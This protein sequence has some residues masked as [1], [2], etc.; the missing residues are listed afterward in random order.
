MLIFTTEPFTDRETGT[1][2]ISLMLVISIPKGTRAEISTGLHGRKM[3]TIRL[4]EVE[5]VVDQY[6]RLD[7]YLVSVIRLF[8]LSTFPFQAVLCVGTKTHWTLEKLPK[9]INYLPPLVIEEMDC[10]QP[11]SR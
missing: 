11:G 10:A 6:H 8:W 2:H 3:T 5:R 1:R 4:L 9:V 7:Y